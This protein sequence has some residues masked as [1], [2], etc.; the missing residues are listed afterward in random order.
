MGP[1]PELSHRAPASPKD[2][3][4]D[5]P[6]RRAH[7]IG[8]ATAS[9]RA[10]RDDAA[11]DADADADV[12]VGSKAVPIGVRAGCRTG[13]AQQVLRDPSLPPGLNV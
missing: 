5:R 9:L 6:R 10:R 13:G 8:R 7:P 1:G 4:N 11:A 3:A 2:P 12:A